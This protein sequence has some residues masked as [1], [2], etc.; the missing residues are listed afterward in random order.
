MTLTLPVPFNATID[1]LPSVGGDT[2][3]GEQSEGT[4]QL[5]LTWVACSED[6]NTSKKDVVVHYSVSE[7]K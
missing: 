7:L 3:V 6:D 4:T 2:S 1:T 5:K